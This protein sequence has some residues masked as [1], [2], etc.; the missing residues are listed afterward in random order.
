[1]ARRII[2]TATF[3][4]VAN[5]PILLTVAK[6]EDEIIFL[7]TAIIRNNARHYQNH[8]GLIT[9]LRQHGL[10][11]TPSVLIS[12]EPSELAQQLQ[13]KVAVWRDKPLALVL[14]G[15]TKLISVIVMQALAELQ[16]VLHYGQAQPC[17]VISLDSNR[18]ESGNYHPAITLDE[19]LLCSG[20][21]RFLQEGRSSGRRIYP[22]AQRLQA[23]YGKDAAFTVAQHT[24]K[25]T[26]LEI[27]PP[28][29]TLLSSQSDKVLAWQNRLLALVKER[30]LPASIK[31]VA[32]LDDDMCAQALQATFKLAGYKPSQSPEI[33]PEIKAACQTVF[34]FLRKL[35][36]AE[37]AQPPKQLLPNCSPLEGFYARLRT[38]MGFTS[39]GLTPENQALGSVFEEAVAARVQC[40]LL[41]NPKWQEIISE[42]WLQ[43]K[44][45]VPEQPGIVTQEFDV[46]LVLKNAVLLHLECKTGMVNNKDMDARSFNMQQAGSK[47]ASQFVVVPLYSDYAKEPWFTLMHS[48][49]QSIA[50]IS[51]VKRLGF[52]LPNQPAEYQYPNLNGE[53]ETFQVAAFETQLEEQL[54]LYL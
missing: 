12:E 31:P 42:V 54:R 44:I 28:F 45:A 26:A 40:W 41:D 38:L 35:K 10:Q 21:Q 30:Q 46:L 8:Q 9:V 22:D 24:A 33:T 7:E 53:L 17:K 3:Q 13:A 47:L 49:Y 6:A 43:T 39:K 1:M 5:L 50:R 23:R 15:G 4:T 29:N 36:E 51:S 48:T 32:K 18:V 27:F 11:V 34:G 52:T 25:S 14:N 37:E 20:Y 19:V 2:V 16:P